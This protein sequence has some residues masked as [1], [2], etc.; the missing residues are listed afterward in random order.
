MARRSRCRISL[1]FR[2]WPRT[3]GL[4]FLPK[5]ISFG[6]SGISPRLL[7]FGACNDIVAYDPWNV[8]NH[9]TV[10]YSVGFGSD[11]KRKK[12]KKIL[13]KAFKCCI[14]YKESERN[15]F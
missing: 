7:G 14:L 5:G 15:S 6:R 10:T 8:F 1:S 12:V 11:K 3:E 2:D 13:D 9:L 4:V